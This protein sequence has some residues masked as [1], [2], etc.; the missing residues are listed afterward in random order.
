VWL[1]ACSSLSSSSAPSTSASD[2]EPRSG[3]R[4]KRSRGIAGPEEARRVRMLH[5]HP[6]RRQHRLLRRH[7]L[8]LKADSGWIVNC[9]G[10]DLLCI[11][12]FLFSFLGGIGNYMVSGFPDTSRCC[13][14]YDCEIGEAPIPSSATSFPCE[15][16]WYCVFYRFCAS[17]HG[18]FGVMRSHKFDSWRCRV[19]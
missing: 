4:R 11:S 2:I 3:C 10:Q 5:K 19:E 6:T 9:T 8:R 16:I 7:P 12:V 18:S 14:R 1:S 13:V 17:A 15:G